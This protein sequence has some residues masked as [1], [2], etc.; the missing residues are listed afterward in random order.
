MLYN[1]VIRYFQKQFLSPFKSLFNGYIFYQ[2]KNVLS[3]LANLLSNFQVGFLNIFYQFSYTYA[4]IL[5]CPTE[6][7][8]DERACDQFI[9]FQLPAKAKHLSLVYYCLS[10]MK[11]LRMVL[12]SSQTWQTQSILNLSI[13]IEGSG[14]VTHNRF[15]LGKLSF[16]S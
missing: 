2:L 11:I 7:F 8:L 13:Q 16:K 12:S 9:I 14:A 1:N 15:A 3:E 10:C 5:K 6:G 4:C